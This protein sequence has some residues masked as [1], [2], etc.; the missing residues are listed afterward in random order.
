MIKNA[1]K[2][3]GNVLFFPA[4]S[5][6]LFVVYGSCFQLLFQIPYV[7]NNLCFLLNAT[8]KIAKT[9]RCAPQTNAIFN[10]TQET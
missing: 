7:S 9:R 10:V 3:G 4:C 6:E 8:L 1:P 5:S 2:G